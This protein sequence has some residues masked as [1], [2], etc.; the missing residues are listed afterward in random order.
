MSPVHAVQRQK[1]QRSKP[2]CVLWY[3]GQIRWTTKNERFHSSPED[4]IVLLCTKVFLV[5]QRFTIADASL[6]VALHN[7]QSQAGKESAAM[8]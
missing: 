5:G 4:T 2:F 7:L 6:S 3:M 1:E 8:R